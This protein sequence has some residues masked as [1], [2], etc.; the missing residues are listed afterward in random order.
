MLRSGDGGDIPA[1][2]GGAMQAAQ[3]ATM[4]T[5]PRLGDAM[6]SSA[7]PGVAPHSMVAPSWRGVAVAVAPAVIVAVLGLEAAVRVAPGDPILVVLVLLHSV[8]LV[9]RHWAPRVVLA[10][11]VAATAVQLLLGYPS[12]NAVLGQYVAATAVAERM[13]RWRSVTPPVVCFAVWIV[14]ATLGGRA[15]A[16]GV[17]TEAVTA[18]VAWGF[19]DAVRRR[20][21]VVAALSGDITRLEREQALVARTAALDERFRIGRDLHL[22]VGKALDAI[23]LQAGLGRTLLSSDLQAA[24]HQISRIEAIGRETLAEMDRFLGLLRG[25]STA[26]MSQPHAEPS[27]P[28]SVENEA[29]PAWRRAVLVAPTIVLAPIA[30][31]EIL[32]GPVDSAPLRRALLGFALAQTLPLLWRYRL[33][34]AVLV[35]VTAA[36]VVPLLLGFPVGNGVIAVPVAV[37]AVASTTPR[38]MSIL[39]LTAA[40]AAVSV[41]ALLGAEPPWQLVV[42]VGSFCAAGWFIGDATRLAAQY[43]AFLHLRAAE[44][45]RERDLHVQ[46]AV[47]HERLEIAR[48]LHDSVGH[49]VSL[50]VLQAGAARLAVGTGT[51]GADAALQAIEAAGRT[52]LADMDRSTALLPGVAAEALAPPPHLGDLVGLTDQM[53]SAGLE[54]ELT[55]AGRSAPLPLSMQ[56]SVFR[57]VQEALTNVAKH[58]PGSIVRVGVRHH[59]GA[60]EVDVCDDGSGGCASEPLL[61]TGGRG[62]VGMRERVELFGGELTCGPRPA[63]G[64]RVLARFPLP[65]ETEV[66]LR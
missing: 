65:A 53:R 7:Q 17:L 12:T 25:R 39:A 11:A 9:V 4:V 14:A 35:T 41:A 23:V 46:E 13:Q 37:H 62:Q 60:L 19:A 21:A 34:L 55:F 45:E 6:T 47:A 31:L 2:Y 29:G 1:P 58:A 50:A 40:V 15:T 57:V 20:R 5:P 32:S 63:G 42:V 26:P 43:R 28:R 10:V 59:R 64:Y 49:A 16:P 61:P 27:L 24:T 30:I 33:P 48:E 36:A 44:I 54:V 66:D 18:L 3:F 51:A 56:A 22:V 8:P 52:A 38:V